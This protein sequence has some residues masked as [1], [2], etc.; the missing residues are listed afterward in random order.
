MRVVMEILGHSTMTIT[1]NLYSHVAP[2]VTRDAADRL[3]TL[4]G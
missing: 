4:L 1:A 3:Q 2:E